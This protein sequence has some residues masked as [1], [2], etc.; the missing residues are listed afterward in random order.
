MGYAFFQN[1]P[2]ETVHREIADT[3]CLAGLLSR[4][5]PGGAHYCLAA[6]NYL[7]LIR[8]AA[9]RLSVRICVLVALPR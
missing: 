7:N 6:R 8:G 4:K 5:P 2:I 3:D 1:Y 9:R